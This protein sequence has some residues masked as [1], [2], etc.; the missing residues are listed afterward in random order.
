M[1][2]AAESLWDE[3]LVVVLSI[4]WARARKRSTLMLCVLAW[5]VI[6][7]CN[8]LYQ[9]NIYGDTGA[10]AAFIML[11]CVALYLPGSTGIR[12]LR[13]LQRGMRIGI[14]IIAVCRIG[15]LYDIPLAASVLAFLAM[16]SDDSSFQHKLFGI[17]WGGFSAIHWSLQGYMVVAFWSVL[18]VIQSALVLGR[19]AADANRAELDSLRAENER[20]QTLAKSQKARLDEHEP[21]MV[22]RKSAVLPEHSKWHVVR[23]TWG[24]TRG[25]RHAVHVARSALSRKAQYGAVG[26]LVLALAMACHVAICGPD[27]PLQSQETVKGVD[28]LVFLV[29]KVLRLSEPLLGAFDWFSYIMIAVYRATSSPEGRLDSVRPQLGLFD[30]ALI[31]PKGT[32]DLQTIW[33]VPMRVNANTSNRQ[34]FLNLPPSDCEDFVAPADSGVASRIEAWVKAKVKDN[35]HTLDMNA[36]HTIDE[37]SRFADDEDTVDFTMRRFGTV[38]PKDVDEWLDK[39]SDTALTRFVFFGLGAHRVEPWREYGNKRFILRTNQLAALPVRPGFDTYGGDAVFDEQ[40][41]VLRI[42]RM[43][44]G[45]LVTYK[46]GDAKWEYAKFTFRSTVF[47]LVTVIDHLWAVHLVTANVFVQASKT[48]LSSEH[49]L[50]RFLV[51]FLFQTATVNDNARAFLISVGGFGP[52]NFAITPEALETVWANGAKF[53]VFQL[54]WYRALSER[55]PKSFARLLREPA[56][57]HHLRKKAGLD[58]PYNEQMA[59]LAGLFEQFFEGFLQVYYPTPGDLVRDGEVT[60]FMNATTTT[61]AAY[62]GT[63]SLENSPGGCTAAVAGCARVLDPPMVW[64]ELKV[65][66]TLLMRVVTAVHRHVGYVAA[67]GQDVRFC[68]FAW[69]RGESAGTRQTA[70][71][72]AA[73][74][75]LTSAAQPKLMVSPGSDGDWS[76]LW[77]REHRETGQPLPQTELSKLRKTFFTFQMGLAQL[78]E[79]IDSENEAAPTRRFPRNFTFTQCNPK[80]LDTS[81]SV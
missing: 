26:V 66:M 23:E 50:R 16:V 25:A 19:L 64:Q 49:P 78:S 74:T 24:A 41:R 4:V 69:P 37:T 13:Y 60:D 53:T 76:R 28:G 11:T 73:L 40:W 55:D 59:Q 61:L 52:R 42:D 7:L 68:A 32:M 38:Y 43:E 67:Y 31:K 8:A 80:F 63:S 29:S 47:T 34:H 2:A 35:L 45:E 51:P 62:F 14:A 10:I 27:D 79:K 1:G 57:H 15:S 58:Q 9:S 20:L 30:A 44:D 72:Q 65:Q 22:R 17:M 46:P 70:I 56:F 39:Y 71:R 3:L 12:W 33:H 77:P 18:L 36:S 5:V 54:P 6:N 48:Y 21:S 81:V 75:S